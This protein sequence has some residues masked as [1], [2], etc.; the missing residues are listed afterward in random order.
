[1]KLYRL[2]VRVWTVPKHGPDKGRVVVES[3]RSEVIVDNL[4]TALAMAREIMNDIQHC[5]YTGRHRGFVRLFV[6]KIFN[7]GT[8]ARF[9]EDEKTYIVED[10]F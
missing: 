2:D 3:E 9:P 4:P 8:L 7:S 10:E 6:P 5:R 1:M